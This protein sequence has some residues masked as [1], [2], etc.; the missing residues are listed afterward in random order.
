MTSRSESCQPFLHKNGEG[1]RGYGGNPNGSPGCE[2]GI[3]AELSDANA[4][5]TR[6]FISAGLLG[7]HPDQRTCPAVADLSIAATVS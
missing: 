5:A 3:L 7:A 4:S 1:F 6:D 2:Q